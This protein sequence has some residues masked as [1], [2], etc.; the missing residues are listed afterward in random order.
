MKGE[1][2]MLDEFNIIKNTVREF[3]FYKIFTFDTE[4]ERHNL[5]D[6]TDDEILTF[7]N[8]DIFDGI[9]HYYSEDIDEFE[10]TVMQLLI[11]Y[12][13]ITFFAHN[14][15]HDLRTLKLIKKLISNEYFGL[16]NKSKLL[17]KIIYIKFTNKVNNHYVL[18]FIDSMNYF[19]TNIETLGE[20]INYGKLNPEN[21]NV[22]C[23][24]WNKLLRIEGKQ[25]V[26]IDTEI[27]YIAINNFINMRYSYGLSLASTSFNEIKK[28]LPVNIYYPKS[29]NN[30]ALTLYRGGIVIPYKLV[31]DKFLYSYDVNSLYPF[32]M[33]QFPYSVKFKEK[34]IDYRWL[35]D[36]I[37][38]NTYNFVIKCKY[39]TD[40]I[41]KFSPVL[42][43]YDN[44]LIP[45]Q[46]NYCWVNGREY[47]YLIQNGFNV[48]VDEAYSFYNAFIF[49]DFVEYFYNKRLESKTEYESYFNK[50]IM[51]SGYGKTGQHKSFSEI[52][53]FDDIEDPVIAEI[54]NDYIGSRVEINGDMYNIYDNFYSVVK[55][56]DPKYS[57]LIASE[58]TSNAR[59]VNYDYSK[60][61]G[62]DNLYY[63][64]TDSFMSDIKIDNFIGKELGQVK[65][66][67]S[68]YF[69][70]KA[71]KDYTFYGI[72][73]KKKCSVCNGKENALH[74][75]IKGVNTIP[76][77]NE[78]ISRKWT[79]LKFE[80]ADNVFIFSKLQ[81]LQRINKKLYYQDNGIGRN[82][83]DYKEY[84]KYANKKIDIEIPQV[85]I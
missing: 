85:I 46:N 33:K 44:Q 49:K 62:F 18:Q 79:R 23:D 63:T 70:I 42:V 45:F 54:I 3:N 37:K 16:V 29:F 17:D 1:W 21:Y 73:N 48:I 84:N 52:V 15:I 13:R 59:L 31:E 77:G 60:I 34:V 40:D 20:M 10:K 35:E 41:T 25:R 32:V 2:D 38:N 83:K 22:S 24:E 39:F 51:N 27:L 72:C 74:Y 67:K 69:N 71:P 53:N 80:M 19:S 9:N 78:Y 11:K 81:K 68:G 8:Y 30:V 82:W 43:K 47:L 56:V 55:K 7:Y 50:T 66:E 28:R 58:I 26:T 76:N 12:K 4:S 61:I 65:I 75:V 6:E 14:I 57:P 36:D 5:D 64:D